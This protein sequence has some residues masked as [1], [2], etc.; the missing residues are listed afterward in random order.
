MQDSYTYGPMQFTLHGDGF[1]TVTIDE[2]LKEFVVTEDIANGIIEMSIHFLKGRRY[3]FLFL[4]K[5]LRV[6]VDRSVINLIANHPSLLEVK[7]AEAVVSTSFFG[8]ILVN[9]YAYFF[10]PPTPVRVFRTE[11]EARKWLSQ[12]L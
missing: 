4:Y 5:D 9:F 6:K 1:L 12:F 7:K 2:T 3:P 8:R 10:H 11:S